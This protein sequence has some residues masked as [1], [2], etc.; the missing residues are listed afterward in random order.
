[1]Y[2]MFLRGGAIPQEL[3]C[4]CYFLRGGYML[5]GIPGRKRLSMYTS[6]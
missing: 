2:V 3:F 5:D 4:V 6:L 1:M